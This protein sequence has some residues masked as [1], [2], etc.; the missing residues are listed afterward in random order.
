[1]WDA[2]LVD[3]DGTLADTSPL[4]RL[5]GQARRSGNWTSYLEAVATCDPIIDQAGAA[6]VNVLPEL[7]SRRIPTAIVTNSPARAAEV[8]LADQGFDLPVIGNAQKP[9]RKGLDRAMSELGVHRDDDEV[10]LI[11]DSV[12]GAMAA[13]RA[14]IWSGTFNPIGDINEPATFFIPSGGALFQPDR[15]LR[16]TGDP[17]TEGESGVLSTE[18]ANLPAVVAGRYRK[19]TRR[20]HPLSVAVRA[21]KSLGELA[22]WP[23]LLTTARDNLVAVGRSMFEDPIITW[24][25]P[26][27]GKPDRIAGL[28]ADLPGVRS[29]PLLGFARKAD[30][31]RGLS[32]SARQANVHEAMTAI[33]G[34]VDRPVLIFDDVVTTG[35]TLTEAARALRSAGVAEVGFLAI[36]KTAYREYGN[37][38][39][40]TRIERPHEIARSHLQYERTTQN[41]ARYGGLVDGDQLLFYLALGEFD[42]LSEPK[43]LMVVVRQAEQS[44]GARFTLVQRQPQAV[45]F[46]AEELADPMDIKPSFVLLPN[47]VV[48]GAG[49]PDHVRVQWEPSPN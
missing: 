37:P 47:T 42:R 44:E 6:V 40:W 18:I 2:V 16:L 15:L 38:A 33:G 25:P 20:R 12:D 17:W 28:F 8:W 11:D 35:A 22:G 39:G 10:V 48:S 19:D 5:R 7:L 30:S 24:I 3:F 14:G 1:M 43:E 49:H 46:D 13:D 26:H 45:Q 32:P 4:E 36:A 31:Q 9:G 34:T 21:S 27:E 41:F 23:E 29:E